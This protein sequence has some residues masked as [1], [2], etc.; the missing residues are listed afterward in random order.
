[1]AEDLSPRFEG[2]K[3]PMISR[4]AGGDRR[5]VVFEALPAAVFTLSRNNVI[6][7][8]NAACEAF[9]EIGKSMLIGQRLDRLL[10]FDSPLLTLIAQ[11][12][13]RGAAINEYRVDLG[14]P[15]QESEKRVDV[16]CALL[17]GDDGGQSDGQAL[18]VLQERTIAEKIDRQL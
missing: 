5:S 7:D 9:F 11:V 15:G 13:E 4:D 8:A 10:P 3:R 1:M 17:P 2:P 12:R 6:A 16:H 14:R 18:V